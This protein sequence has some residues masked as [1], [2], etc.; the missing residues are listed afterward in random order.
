[1]PTTATPL[2]LDQARHLDVPDG[3]RIAY[4]ETGLTDPTAPVIVWVHGL[5]LDSRSWSAQREFFDTR[6]R[7][8]FLDLRGY[9]ASS[10]LPP[11]TTGVTALYVADLAALIQ[12]LGLTAPLLVGFASAG[13][14]ALR[15]AAEHP[16]LVGKLAVLNGSPKFR[17]SADWPYGFDEKGIARFT[18]AAAEGGIEGITDAVL[19]PEVVFADVDDAR[20][21]E[22]S[23][24]FREMSHNAGVRTL[25]GFFEDISLDDD[26][27]LLP[28]IEAPTLLMASTIGQEVPTAVSLYLRTTIARARLAELPGADHF[29]FATRPDLVNTLLDSFLTS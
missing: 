27:A 20:A 24:W 25:L 17:R 9:G 16:G 3:G 1:M 2:T 8:V 6:A 10:E 22:L 21:A 28:D 29:A 7:N 14:V 18:D 15:F 12:H 11:D 4:Y 5:P 26:R 13:H 19:D 23:A